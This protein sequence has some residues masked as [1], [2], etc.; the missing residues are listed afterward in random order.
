LDNILSFIRT[1]LQFIDRLDELFS[2]TSPV[3]LRRRANVFAVTHDREG[4]TQESQA[5]NSK[6]IKKATISARGPVRPQIQE[7]MKA[8]ARGFLIDF[9]S[10]A[11]IDLITNAM[12]LLLESKKSVY[13]KDWVLQSIWE[14]E[15]NNLPSKVQSHYE[16]AIDQ[17]LNVIDRFFDENEL[18]LEKIKKGISI[19]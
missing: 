11:K 2:A 4:S 5:D 10:E 14:I 9:D 19:V 12:E 15:F 6:W 3:A 7:I 1:P 13:F 18:W 8:T 16:V 17:G